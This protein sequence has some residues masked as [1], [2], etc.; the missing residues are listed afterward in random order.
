M[1]TTFRPDAERDGSHAAPRRPLR[2][3]VVDDDPTVADVLASLAACWG[4]D[5]RVCLDGGDALTGAV[6]YNPDVVLLDLEMP[7]SGGAAVARWLRTQP[8]FRR[9]P[10]IAV[11]GHAD[12]GHR[13]E[14][15]AAGMVA[16]LVKPVEPDRLREL[17]QGVGKGRRW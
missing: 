16:Y 9:V 5:V 2:V 6:V 17:L 13:Q 11:T 3:L 4:H 8:G 15:A 12:K 1:D 14:A 7:P 10:I